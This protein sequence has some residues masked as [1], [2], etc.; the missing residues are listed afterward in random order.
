M[1]PQREGGGNLL[2]VKKMCAALKTLSNSERNAYIIMERIVPP[3]RDTYVL[4]KQGEAGL[5]P[6]T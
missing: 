4:N 1:K 2:T 5:I 3:V 6:G